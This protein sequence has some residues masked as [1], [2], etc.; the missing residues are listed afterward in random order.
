[1]SRIVCDDK[2]DR[3][4][5]PLYAQFPCRRADAV[6]DGPKNI[7]TPFDALSACGGLSA[8]LCCLPSNIIRVITTSR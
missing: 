8:L 3:H 5:D 4:S 1:M 6:G 7:L 2:Q